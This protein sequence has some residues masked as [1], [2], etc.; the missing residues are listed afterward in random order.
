MVGQDMPLPQWDKDLNHTAQQLLDHSRL[1]QDSSPDPT[2]AQ[3]AVNAGLNQP[4]VASLITHGCADLGA[5]P[6]LR[7][8]DIKLLGL[9]IGQQARLVHAIEGL[10]PKQ[11]DPPS[12]RTLIPPMAQSAKV[13][14]N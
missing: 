10:R 3:W 11:T 2:F 9:T 5:L 14:L 8:A 4:T 1:E 13:P 7:E 12:A 6:L